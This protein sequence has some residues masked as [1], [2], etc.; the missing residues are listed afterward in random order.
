MESTSNEHTTVKANEGYGLAGIGRVAGALGIVLVASVPLTWF[1]TGEGGFSAVLALGR[2]AFCGAGS[3]PPFFVAPA[4]FRLRATLDSSGPMIFCLMEETV[5]DS[6][7]TMP[8]RPS[9]SP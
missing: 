1:L 2:A 6:V 3:V 9:L 4:F 8:P 7:P 5:P